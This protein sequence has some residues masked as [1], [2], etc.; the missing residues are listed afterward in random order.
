MRTR[1]PALAVAGIAASVI[2]SAASAQILA[3]GTYFIHNHP[4]GFMNPPPYGLRLDELYNVDNSQSDVFTFD[5]NDS[6]SN[7]RLTYDGSTI[8]I[9]G[10][11]LGGRD[12]GTGYAN[13]QYLG[14]YVIDFTYRVNVQQSNI[15]D[16]L[17]VIPV[18]PANN[19]TILTPLGDTKI[20]TEEPLGPNPVTDYT[21][22]LGNENDDLGHRGFPGLSGWGW[23]RV[24]GAYN[25]GNDWIFTIGNPVPA[26]GIAGLLGLAGL[27]A[28]RR[29]R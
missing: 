8:R 26:P 28:S 29:K 3:P 23:L 14:N 16:D 10:N 5:F 18:N 21:F 7:M 4:D 2:A 24:D 27:A 20:L 19:G 1:V 6:S 17:V 13:D 9:F 15:D 25:S 12:I 22:R 11:T